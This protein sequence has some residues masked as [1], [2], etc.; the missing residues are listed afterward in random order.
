MSVSVAIK[1]PNYCNL[2]DYCIS[3]LMYIESNYINNFLIV[4]KNNNNNKTKADNLR[5]C[6]PASFQSDVV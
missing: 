2:S 3:A 6:L 5:I 1:D 4:L